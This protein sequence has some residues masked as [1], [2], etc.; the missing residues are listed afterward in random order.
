MTLLSQH[1]SLST[2]YTGRPFIDYKLE[3]IAGYFSLP[4]APTARTRQARGGFL[5]EG[6]DCQRVIMAWHGIFQMKPTRLTIFLI[7]PEK[8]AFSAI[9]SPYFLAKRWERRIIYSPALNTFSVFVQLS[10]QMPRKFRT[11]VK[12]PVFKEHWLDNEE[13]QY[14]NINLYLSRLTRQFNIGLWLRH[15]FMITQRPTRCLNIDDVKGKNV[16]F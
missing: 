7:L 15:I 9:I 2:H 8:S 16:F 1:L 11:V 6:L 5:L 3:A 10:T 13:V 12:C 4:E 14:W